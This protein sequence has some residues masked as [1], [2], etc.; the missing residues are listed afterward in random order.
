VR[1]TGCHRTGLTVG[2]STGPYEP[3]LAFPFKYIMFMRLSQ[4]EIDGTT[5]KYVLTVSSTVAVSL[6]AIHPMI[7]D[8][9]DDNNIMKTGSY[10][11]I[12]LP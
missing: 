1:V 5:S 10:S 11:V 9:N 12:V 7:D 6:F 2:T 4:R 3:V 8:D